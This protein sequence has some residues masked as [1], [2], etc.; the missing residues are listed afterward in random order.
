MDNFKCVRNLMWLFAYWLYHCRYDFFFGI[1]RIKLLDHAV[2]WHTLSVAG[3]ECGLFCNFDG[4]RMPVP[5]IKDFSL[6]SNSIQH[7]RVFSVTC[8]GSLTWHPDLSTIDCLLECM[9]EF[10]GDAFCDPVN[11]REM[12]GWDGGDCCASTVQGGMVEFLMDCTYDCDCLDP[13]AANRGLI[14]QDVSG[15]SRKRLTSPRIAKRRRLR[16]LKHNK[17]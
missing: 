8:T 16:L 4:D 5:M 12:C 15:N 1:S 17:H 9:P 6:V 13:R 3:S 10:T 11:N 2:H 7:T 14:T